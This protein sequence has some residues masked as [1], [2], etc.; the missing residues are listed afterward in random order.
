MTGN[1][2]LRTVEELAVLR[3]VWAAENK[4]V[5]WTNGCFDIL[6]AGHVRS[7]RDA[8]SLGDLL[9][10]GINSDA[11]VRAAK[12]PLRPVVCQED[13]AEVVAALESVDY[14]T[15]FSEPDPVA[16]LSLVKPDIHCKGADYANGLRPVPERDT[17][18]AYGGKVCF[19]PFHEGRST[20]GMI[21]RICA[22]AAAEAGR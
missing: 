9:I 15:I 18:L 5:V 10:V 13:R 8:R 20:T 2:K 4:K 3:K 16:A 1:R 22:A 19:L 17:V 6:H 14:V 21:Q 12:G 11:G 7:F